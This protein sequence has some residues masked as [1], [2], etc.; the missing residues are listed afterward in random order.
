MDVALLADLVFNVSQHERLLDS[1][2]LALADGGVALSFYAF[3]RPHKAVEDGQ[4]IER[5]QRRG[6][7]CEEVVKTWGGLAF[8][9][10]DGDE[11][12]RG[13]VHGWVMTLPSRSERA[14]LRET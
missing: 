14:S 7:R 4:F 10:D 2:E 9:D 1:C 6:W 11:Q 12:L 13:T 3:H 8:P 5:A